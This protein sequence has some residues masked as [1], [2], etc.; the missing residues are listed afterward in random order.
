MARPASF[1][2]AR[3]SR[4][5]V[6]YLLAFGFGLSGGGAAAAGEPASKAVRKCCVQRVVAQPSRADGGRAARK[7]AA[8]SAHPKQP[9]LMLAQ[10]DPAEK[11]ATDASASPATP[12]TPV[13]GNVAAPDAKDRRL[14]VASVFASPQPAAATVSSATL[15]AAAAQ[16]DE[17]LAAVTLN[18]RATSPGAP[19]LRRSGSLY[20]RAADLDAWRIVWPA[21]ARVL[22]HGGTKFV[23]LAGVPELQARFDPQRQQLDL[24]IPL[25][26]LRP[27]EVDY[28]RKPLA[29]AS[30]P[31]SYGAFLGYGL[32]GYQTSGASSYSA[33]LGA[34]A[35]GPLGVLSSDLLASGGAGSGSS[36]VRLDTTLRYDMPERMLTLVAG[37]SLLPP[38]GPWGRALRI[39]GV[40]FGT[41]FGTQPNFPTAPLQTISGTAAVPSVVDILVNGQRIGQRT[42]PAGNFTINDVPYVTGAGNVQAVVRDPLGREQVYAQSYY[43][44]SRLLTPG[45]QEWGVEAGALRYRF[46]ESSGDYRDFVGGGF[47]RRGFNSDLT[48]EVRT[49]LSRDVQVLGGAVDASL[50]ERVNGTVSAAWSN[51]DH[52]R[53]ALYGVGVQRAAQRGPSF[54]L[55]YVGADQGFRQPGDP[56]DRLGFRD[57]VS[58]TAGLPL[59]RYGSLVA[60]YSRSTFWGDR[61]G[62]SIGTLSYYL[63]LP[64]NMF[65]SLN[66]S[67][68][69]SGATGT[70]ATVNLTIPF[71]D[72][73]TYANAGANWSSEAGRAGDRALRAQASVTRSLPIG[74]GYG[75]RVAASD[76]GNAQAMATVQNAFAQLQG[77]AGRWFGQDYGRLTLSGGAVWLDGRVKL[78]RDVTQ[79]FALVDANGIPDAPVY[80]NG[81]LYGRTLADGSLVVPRLTAYMPNEISIRAKDFP[82]SYSLGDTARIVTPY[83]RSGSVVRFE[84]ERLREATARLLGPGGESLPT[85]TRVRVSDHLDAYVGLDGEAFLR[86][87]GARNTLTASVDGV[88]CTYEAN[89]PEEGGEIIP[90]LGALPCRR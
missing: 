43:L 46:G 88:V 36:V 45:L 5:Q 29:I 22:E 11:R 38:V 37:D 24:R 89:F 3:L 80:L 48:G 87:L 20:A 28:G 9:Q 56:A 78:A 26:R 47:L 76:G 30:A 62:Y 10:V 42:V 50:F 83:Y 15:L 71:A 74:D 64:G 21:S 84:V 18:S 23:E 61:P 58:G 51:A 39:G 7:K 2:P 52:A 33:L 70:S 25:S 82:I 55:Q 57:L 67:Q 19:M 6:A 85:G 65:L 81:Q 41:N 14:S 8:K 75:Y 90:D 4:P 59:G 69:I 13:V 53:G 40:Q 73:R 79:S 27:V 68:G 44:S 60:G 12:A 77:E 54:S 35:F 63:T 34:G 72:H 66:L 32:S 49:Q 17:L 31:A 86:V 1:R 16:D